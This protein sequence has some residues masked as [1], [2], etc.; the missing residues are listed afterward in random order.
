[1]SATAAAT[2]PIPRRVR[3]VFASIGIGTI[4][5]VGVGVTN[6][7]NA[8]CVRKT[9]VGAHS[10]SFVRSFVP[11]LFCFVLCDTSMSVR[12]VCESSFSKGLALPIGLKNIRFSLLFVAFVRFPRTHRHHRFAFVSL[13]SARRAGRTDG[14]RRETRRYNLS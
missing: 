7:K 3:R 6:A 9:A 11:F 2:Y 5:I 13:V 12:S 4:G 10:R 8:K 1:M 14:V